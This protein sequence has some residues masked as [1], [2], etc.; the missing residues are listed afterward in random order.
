MDA[1]LG[2]GR[3]MAE[4][5]MADECLIR[6]RTGKATDPVTAV[7]TPTYATVYEGRCRVQQPTSAAREETPGQAVLLMLRFELQVPVSAVGIAAD[8]EVLLTKAAH[9]PDLLNREFV[10]RGLSHKS[11][12]VMRR[13]EVEERTS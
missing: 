3:A 2:R 9:D 11:H 6:R 10:V 13:V 4:R 8:D 5:L 1:L 12:P 7:V